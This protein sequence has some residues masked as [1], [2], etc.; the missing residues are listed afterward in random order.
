MSVQYNIVNL[1]ALL[2]GVTTFG[3]VACRKMKISKKLLDFELLTDIEQK[4]QK[5]S[6]RS[7]LQK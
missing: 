2:H 3:I 6:L 7:V 1:I 4:I 5:Q